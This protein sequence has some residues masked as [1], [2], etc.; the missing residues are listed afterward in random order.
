MLNPAEDEST[1]VDP[2]DDLL[3]GGVVAGHAAFGEHIEVEAILWA[4]K[5]GRVVN[6]IL[7][8]M[9]LRFYGRN[10]TLEDSTLLSE[11]I[12]CIETKL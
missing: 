1:P 3:E 11:T 7:W 8:K 5:G 12:I 2:D 10:F 6:C 9:Y 4:D